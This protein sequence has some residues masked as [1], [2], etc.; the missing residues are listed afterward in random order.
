MPK[1]VKSVDKK[2]ILFGACRS[3]TVGGVEI[4][5]TDEGVEVE[6]TQEFEEHGYDE[7]TDAAMLEA[8][9][10]QMVIRT[11]LAEATLD[12][13]KIAWNQASAITEDT[14][15][16]KTRTLNIGVNSPIVEYAL[17]FIGMGPTI[18]EGATER[19]Y[20]AF[21]AVQMSTS[22]HSIRKGQ[23]VVFP[24]EFRILPDDSKPDAEQYGTIVDKVIV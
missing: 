21:R 15:P 19:T 16:P 23:K 9:S 8:V 11:S 3:F 13:L 14:G 4:G 7:S 20:T 2:N 5:G 12:N 17:E 10:T 6:F 18:T 1:T 22:A 24:V